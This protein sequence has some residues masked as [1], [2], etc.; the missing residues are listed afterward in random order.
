[1]SLG[2]R[3]KFKGIRKQLS[4]QWKMCEM[5]KRL[6]LEIPS[7]SRK[8]LEFDLAFKSKSAHKIPREESYGRVWVGTR[9][10]GDAAELLQEHLQSLV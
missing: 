10:D 4:T 1:M 2:S 3:G 6:Q 7:F 9:E 5:N 8:V